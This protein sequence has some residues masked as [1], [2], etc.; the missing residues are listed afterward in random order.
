MAES[1]KEGLV[2]ENK[3]E[4]MLTDL[5]DAK[6]LQRIQDDFFEMTGIASLVMDSEGTI[7]TEGSNFTDFCREYMRKSPVGCERCMQCDKM[8]MEMAVK[9]GKTVF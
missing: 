3:D 7:V 4:L 2:M 5:I 9:E 8:G 6:T 1:G